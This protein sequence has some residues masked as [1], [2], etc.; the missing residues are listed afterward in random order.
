MLF[1]KF[2][3]GW[4]SLFFMSAKSYNLSTI[5]GT[6][7]RAINSAKTCFRTVETG[8]SRSLTTQYRIITC[9]GWKSSFKVYCLKFRRTF[10]IISDDK[11]YR[12]V[13]T[14]SRATANIP[15]KRTLVAAGQSWN[16]GNSSGENISKNK[17]ICFR[18]KSAKL[19]TSIN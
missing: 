9:V 4:W 14:V 6:R 8:E 12:V 13:A 1:K 5:T 3:T 19:S 15:T 10:S 7:M 11:Q 16:I 17:H 18:K 2:S